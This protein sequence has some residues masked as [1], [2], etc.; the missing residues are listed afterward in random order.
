VNWPQKTK[1][2]FISV[3][4]LAGKDGPVFCGE[5]GD[6]MVRIEAT[7]HSPFVRCLREVAIFTDPIIEGAL[8]G[9]YDLN[10]F[11]PLRWSGE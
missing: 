4:E 2:Y 11:R 7:D 8:E 10:V 1:R 9:E 3:S 5:C 6:V